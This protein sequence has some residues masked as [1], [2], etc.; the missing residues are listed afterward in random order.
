MSA[1]DLFSLFGG[2]SGG[3]AI[4]FC[5]LFI[6]GQIVSRGA[7]ED[8]KAQYEDMKAQRDEW[9]RTAEVNGQRADAGTITGQIVRDVMTSLRKELE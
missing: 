8:L 7:H 5:I 6:T 1:G 3:T 4:V 9:K 2:A